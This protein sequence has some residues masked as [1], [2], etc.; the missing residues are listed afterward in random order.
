MSTLC[1]N[2][3]FSGSCSRIVWYAKKRIPLYQ[4]SILVLVDL[5]HELSEQHA[6][7][8]QAWRFNPCF[9]GSCSRI[10]KPRNSKQLKYV[11]ILVLVDLAHEYFLSCQH[12]SIT[13]VS[14]LVL[15][16][17]AHESKQYP[18]NQQFSA[19]SI[20]VLVDL[21][22]ESRFSIFTSLLSGFQ[23]LF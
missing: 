3:C 1:F 8:V 5:A 17:L 11:S 6:I 23:S 12:H 4:V 10:R 14:I 13:F 15:V 19:V 7:I 21:A 20:L 2:P 22:H 18:P 9:S 16:D